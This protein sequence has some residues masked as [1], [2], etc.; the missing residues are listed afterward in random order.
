MYVA[1]RY[2]AQRL[3][4]APGRND[5]PVIEYR[6]HQLALFTQLA[7][8]YAMTFL[9]NHVKRAYLS[10]DGEISA[11]LGVL[12]ALTKALTTWEMTETVAV[13]PRTLRCPGHLQR[14]PDRG[15]RFPA[16]GPG[17]CGG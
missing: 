17:H 5:M 2:A 10:Q 7:K 1:L 9:L 14:Q 3:T 4:N 6:S 16:P 15:L 12:I 11:E 13:L 8:V